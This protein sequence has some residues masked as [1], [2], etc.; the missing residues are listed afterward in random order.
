[1]KSQWRSRNKLFSSN[2]KSANWF[3]SVYKMLARKKNDLAFHRSVGAAP[4][5]IYDAVLHLL[6]WAEPVHSFCSLASFRRL[7]R[8]SE[9]SRSAKARISKQEA[10]KEITCLQLVAFNCMLIYG[11]AH[12]ITRLAVLHFPWTSSLSVTCSTRG[13]LLMVS[14]GLVLFWQWCWAGGQKSQKHLFH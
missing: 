9:K 12:K 6:Y 8:G 2:L 14:A 7:S 4:P 1:M 11:A 10:I 5:F 13:P 3:K